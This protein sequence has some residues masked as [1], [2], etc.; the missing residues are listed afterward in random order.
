M[1]AGDMIAGKWLVKAE[2]EGEAKEL[3]IR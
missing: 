2:G 3:Y 1:K